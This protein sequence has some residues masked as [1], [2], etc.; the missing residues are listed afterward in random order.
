[1]QVQSYTRACPVCKAGVEVDKVR[2]RDQ[3]A[4]GGAGGSA[5]HTAARD[6][7]GPPTPPARTPPRR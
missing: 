6:G 5:M 2:A 4:R 1:M 7:A 3:H